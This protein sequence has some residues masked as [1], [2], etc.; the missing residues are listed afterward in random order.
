MTMNIIAYIITTPILTIM[1]CIER[2]RLKRNI[3][4]FLPAAIKGG[5]S[6]P[7]W[8]FVRDWSYRLNDLGA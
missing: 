2:R 4:A 8:E 3:R 1:H 7:E 5:R 6:C